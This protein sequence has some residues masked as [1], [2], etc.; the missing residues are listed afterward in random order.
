MS[1]CIFVS[2]LSKIVFWQ[3]LATVYIY[4]VIYFWSF[5]LFVDFFIICNLRKLIIA[6]QIIPRRNFGRLKFLSNSKANE[7]L[8]WLKCY[9]MINRRVVSCICSNSSFVVCGR[10]AHFFHITFERHSML[11]FYD[12]S[13]FCNP[14]GS[15]PRSSH[16]HFI[17]LS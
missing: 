4:N 2:L 9:F 16:L 15:P 10:V 6:N 5:Y 13:N 11:L 17:F 12:I 8:P 1:Q 3:R 14:T 7:L